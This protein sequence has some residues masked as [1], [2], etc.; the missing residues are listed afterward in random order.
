MPNT[1]GIRPARLRLSRLTSRPRLQPIG[2]LFLV[3]SVLELIVLVSV[4]VIVPPQSIVVLAIVVILM[5]GVLALLIPSQLLVVAWIV[6]DNVAFIRDK[7]A[8]GIIMSLSVLAAGVPLA[9]LIVGI[10]GKGEGHDG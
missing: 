2:T 3:L 7:I 10:D 8:L 1:I 5:A 4:T 6:Q 9:A